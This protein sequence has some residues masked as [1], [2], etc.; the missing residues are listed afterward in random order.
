[1]CEGFLKKTKYIVHVSYKIAR[2]TEECLL[3]KKRLIPLKIPAPF[4]V[5]IITNL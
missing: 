4:I 2:I 1:M 3:L 5:L